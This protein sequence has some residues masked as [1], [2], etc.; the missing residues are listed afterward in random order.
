MSD[1]S[2]RR[3]AIMFVSRELLADMGCKDIDALKTSQCERDNLCRLMME[4]Q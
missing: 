2:S 1:A 4:V 3:K